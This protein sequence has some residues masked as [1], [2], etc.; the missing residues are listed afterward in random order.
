MP[1]NRLVA[2]SD[3]TQSG[4]FRKSLPFSGTVP[5][6]RTDRTWTFPPFG[7]ETR[8]L[9][10]TTLPT[11]AARTA[12]TY[13]DTSE[14]PDSPPSPAADAAGIASC[15][16]A[17]SPCDDTDCIASRCTIGS[18]VPSPNT[19]L[20]GRA[21]AIV[22]SPP[23][24]CPPPTHVCLIAFPSSDGTEDSLDPTAPQH[25]MPRHN[26]APINPLPI[27]LHIPPIPFLGKSESVP[28]LT[29]HLRVYLVIQPVPTR[30]PAG[31]CTSLVT[32][33][34]TRTAASGRG[35]I[36]LLDQPLT[37]SIQK[38]RPLWPVKSNSPHVPF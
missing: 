22:R 4:D 17:W 19:S 3:F 5:L 23:Q 2:D 12:I 20:A 32:R 25:K 21:S 28:G 16:V 37:T 1:A 15:P 26:A 30:C 10:N 8:L 18:P 38:H 36:S 27:A 33:K 13:R 7:Q 34:Q 29:D 24:G 11:R 6:S 9:L 14:G 31:R 35:P